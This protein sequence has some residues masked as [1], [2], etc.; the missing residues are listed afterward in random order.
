MWVEIFSAQP[1]WLQLYYV[2]LNIILFTAGLYGSY[3]FFVIVKEKGVAYL[4]HRRIE[5]ENYQNY[6]SSLEGK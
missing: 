1:Y 2:I 5:R 6:L 3:R 4:E